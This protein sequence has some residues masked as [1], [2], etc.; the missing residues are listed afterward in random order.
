VDRTVLEE[1]LDG[2]LKNA[3]ENTPD[4][5]LLRVLIESK[6]KRVFVKVEDYGIGI[7]PEN[8]RFIFEG[9]FHTQDTDLYTSKTPYDF[10]AGGKGLDLHRIKIYGERFGFDLT[11]DSRRCIY[12]PTDRDLCPGKIS[13]CRHCQAVEDCIASGGSVFTLSFPT[14]NEVEGVTEKT[15]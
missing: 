5:G 2:L 9:L 13:L 3:I 1:V 15:T 8:R 10:Y 11:M 7:T 6:S 4:E 14:G 12:L